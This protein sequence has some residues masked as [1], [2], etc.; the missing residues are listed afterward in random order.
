MRAN[1][2]SG[3]LEVDG[4]RVVIHPHKVQA[5]AAGTTAIAIPLSDVT[6]FTYKAATRLIAGSATFRTSAE[7]VRVYGVDQ[8]NHLTNQ[9]LKVTWQRKSEDDFAAVRD[10]IQAELSR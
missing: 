9:A 10:A 4:G 7:D 1:G 5:K 2:F 3:D 8:P 6:D